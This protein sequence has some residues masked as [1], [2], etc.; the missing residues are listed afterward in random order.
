MKRLQRRNG[1]AETIGADYKA[2]QQDS[3]KT[4]DLGMDQGPRGQRLMMGLGIS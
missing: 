4:K 3:E 2:K 1:V